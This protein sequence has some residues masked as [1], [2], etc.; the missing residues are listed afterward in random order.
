ME[1]R[2]TLLHN[3]GGAERVAS[4]VGGGLIAYGL[5][6]RDRAGLA[7]AALGGGLI[8]RGLISTR[9]GWQNGDAQ[10]AAVP[11]KQGDR[12]DCSVRINRSREEVY[13]FW[14]NLENLPRFMDN[15][16]SVKVLDAKRSRWAAKRRAGVTVTWEAEIIN[17]IENELIAWQSLPG[18]QVNSAGSVRLADAPNGATDLSISLQYIPPGGAVGRVAAR[19]LGESVGEQ[20]CCDLE[21][22]RNLLETGS[23]T[24]AARGENRSYRRRETAAEEDE[25]AK[26]SEES[27]PASD[28]P[29]WTPETL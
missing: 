11:Y 5:L 24:M 19:L 9:K 14:R 3:V 4:L 16:E 21:K 7:W 26:A 17:E 18:S 22:L 25:V 15:I 2:R 23:V 27:F 10:R 13:R 12:I 20:V 6:R 28:P 29:S 8:Y 1:A